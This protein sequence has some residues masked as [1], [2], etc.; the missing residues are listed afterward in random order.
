MDEL[1]E[2]G[3]AA[4]WKDKGFDSKKD[5]E[6]WLEQVRDILENPKQIDFDELQASKSVQKSEKVYAFTP[7]GDLKELTRGATVL[8]FAFSIHT[9]V[10]YSCTG[11]KVNGKIAALKQS[12]KNGDKVEI[13]TSKLQRP[14]L[15][16]LNFVTTTRARNKIKRALKEDKFEAADKG[17]EILRRK[18]RNWKIEFSDIN[19][20][21]LIKKYKLSSSIDLYSLIYEEKLDLLEIK[22]FFQDT[23]V[24]GSASQPSEKQPLES[25]QAS[26]TNKSPG[27]VLRISKNLDKVNYHLAKCCNPIPGDP[28]FGFVT[29]SKG[30]TIHRKNCP[31][32][33]Q[34]LSRY[35]YRTIPVEWKDTEDANTFTT[36]INVSGVDKVGM[37]NDISEVISND[38]KVNM[39]SVKIES[40]KGIFNGTIKLIVRNTTHLDEL[41][42]RLEDI[43]GITKAVRIG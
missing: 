38:L 6:V 14:K 16:W 35:H 3:Q 36:V 39:L 34:L 37:M 19:I 43:S 26:K 33:R 9:N 20:D 1:A 31:N 21:K 23:A 13:L 4:H 24:Q 10:G 28:V 29:I 2:K 22:R 41:L 5:S 11:A 32:A 18:F 30:I 25:K 27:D 7:D 17:N 15:D 40:G 12:L 8:D 42:H